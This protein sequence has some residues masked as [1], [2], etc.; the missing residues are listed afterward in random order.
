[1]VVENKVKKIIVDQLGVAE[2]VL[3]LVSEAT[4]YITG[5]VLNINGGMYM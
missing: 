4:G 3:F 2:G 1:M 5:Q